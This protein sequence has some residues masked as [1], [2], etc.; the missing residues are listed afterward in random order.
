MF[1][2]ICREALAPAYRAGSA[3]GRRSPAAPLPPRGAC[4]PRAATVAW[5]QDHQPCF[6]LVSRASCWPASLTRAQFPLPMP[7]SGRHTGPYFDDLHCE[8]CDYR[9]FAV[10]FRPNITEQRYVANPG[11]T[12]CIV[13]RLAY[14]CIAREDKSAAAGA[15]FAA[16]GITPCG[17]VQP[18]I[19][20]S[21]S[22]PMPGGH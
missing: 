2:Y 22:P 7:A 11:C 18:S 13:L 10:T 8:H 15:L 1:I 19:G 21:V 6:Y 16:L 17:R 5:L 9:G 3:S 4:A 20:R 14:S 12:D